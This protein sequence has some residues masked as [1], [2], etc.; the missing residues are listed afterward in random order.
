MEGT[1]DQLDEGSESES[2]DDG[3][4]EVASP[5]KGK[6]ESQEP[7]TPPVTRS[8]IKKKKKKSPE[9]KL[10]SGDLIRSDLEAFHI[11]S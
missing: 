10:E 9:K 11:I 4:D 7:K 6:Q 8:N 2:F 1:I 5:S 3:Q